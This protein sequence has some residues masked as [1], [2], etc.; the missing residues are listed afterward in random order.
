MH[1]Y[2]LISWIVFWP[3]SSKVAQFLDISDVQTRS[4]TWTLSN[5]I[6]RIQNDGYLI[7]FFLS[8]YLA[9]LRTEPLDQIL[10]ESRLE[11]TDLFILILLFQMEPLLF[12]SVIHLKMYCLYF[13]Q[14]CFI[15]GYLSCWVLHFG[16]ILNVQCITKI[17]FM[18]Y[19]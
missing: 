18:Y 5:V 2:F 6:G 8:L 14:N 11:D 10:W 1:F 19:T 17:T 7:L 13:L 12:L 15:S 16:T 3:V 9:Y 4:K